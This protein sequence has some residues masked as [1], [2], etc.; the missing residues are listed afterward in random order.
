MIIGPEGGFEPEEAEMLKGKGFRSVS[1]FK[2]I[3][4][5]ETAAVVFTG[6]VRMELE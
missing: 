6:L 1:P 3:L 5:A 4:K 2:P